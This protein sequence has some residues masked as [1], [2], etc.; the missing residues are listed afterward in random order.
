MPSSLVCWSEDSSFELEQP[1]MK[2]QGEQRNRRQDEDDDDTPFSTET[3]TSFKLASVPSS[4]LSRDFAPIV[5]AFASCIDEVEPPPILES[6]SSVGFP[7]SGIF[8]YF[9]DLKTPGSAG[10][11]AAHQIVVTKKS[12]SATMDVSL[13]ENINRNQ[14]PSGC[15]FTQKDETYGKI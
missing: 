13:S 1:H 14:K 15:T 6:F 4:S 8:R 2:A 7:F 5:E 9:F 3:A 10:S 12:F 11:A